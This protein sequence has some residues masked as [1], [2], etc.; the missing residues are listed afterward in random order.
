LNAVISVWLQFAAL[1]AII[2]F[3]GAALCRSGDIIAEKTGL[4]RSWVGFILLA[5]VTSLPELVTGISAVAW[6]QA[7][8]VAVG[9]VLGSC[10]LNLAIL[11]VVDV[12]H[13]RESFYRRAGQGHILSAS[14]GI[15]LIGLAGLGVIVG[16]RGDAYAIGHIGL[17]T[18]LIVLLYAVAARTIFTYERRERESF[19]EAVAERYP[20]V[21][22]RVALVRYVCG[23]VA[24][25]AVGAW[26]P[27]LAVDVARV[28]GWQTTFVGTVFVAAAT[29]LPELSVTISAVRLGAVDLAIANL[30]GSNLFDILIIAIDDLAFLDGPI[31]SHVSPTH[32]VSAVSAAVMSGVVIVGLLY[33]PNVRIAGLVG[34]VSIGLGLLFLLS[35]YATFVYG[36]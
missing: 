24:V 8:N 11:T 4:S 33:R 14:F 16:Q 26:L 36:E 27:F 31:L 25:I 5:T 2:G 32:A 30:L 21:T 1:A 17:Y 22:L 15:V 35:T 23:A 7:P 18:P 3:A 9:D 20:D 13:R 12:L 6:A 19:A 34:W 29:S 28:M 10:V